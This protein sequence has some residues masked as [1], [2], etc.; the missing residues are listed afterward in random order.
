VPDQIRLARF[1]RAFSVSEERWIE[2]GL[3]KLLRAE[4]ERIWP[5]V[6][7]WVRP[8]FRVNGAQSAFSNARL[9]NIVNAVAEAV[10]LIWL[11]NHNV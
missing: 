6:Q 8:E 11:G 3:G 7:Q 2:Q 9:A 10:T 5:A 1:K 4:V